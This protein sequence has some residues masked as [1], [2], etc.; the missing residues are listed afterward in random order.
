MIEVSLAEGIWAICNAPGGLPVSPHHTAA[1][2]DENPFFIEWLGDL[3]KQKKQAS[4][5]KTI[6]IQ[7]IST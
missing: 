3:K 6:A 4:I 2:R 1:V 7:I 5:N